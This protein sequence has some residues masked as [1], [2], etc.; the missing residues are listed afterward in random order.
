MFDHY[1]KA[2]IGAL[3]AGLGA[4]LTALSS[5]HIGATQWVLV[6]IAGLSSFSGVW[7]TPNAPA[8]AKSQAQL[9]ATAADAISAAQSFQGSP[10]TN[11]VTR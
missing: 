11:V 10:T 8:P 1:A 6:I 2:V 3:L 5:G 4:L 7:A 9:D